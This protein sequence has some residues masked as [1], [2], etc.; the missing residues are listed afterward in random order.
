MTLSHWLRRPLVVWWALLVALAGALLVPM[1]HA[2]V[3]VN[4]LGS[5]EVC[6]STGSQTVVVDFDS[7]QKSI[8][9]LAHC[10]FC[11]HA[12]DRLAPPPERPAPLFQAVGGIAV[13]VVRQALFFPLP[14]VAV[15][16]PRG[17]PHVS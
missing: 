8:A 9:Y 12:T 1:S 3:R 6:T 15:P 11:L 16:P 14:L 2:G 5:M 13:P 10:P 4:G 17:P 7:G